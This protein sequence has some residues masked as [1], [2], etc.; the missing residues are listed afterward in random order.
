MTIHT[1]GAILKGAQREE[2]AQKAKDWYLQGC[3]IQSTAEKI[4]RS[5]GATRQLLLEA[6]VK[7]RPRGGTRTRFGSADR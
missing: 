6:G 5:Y 4:G 3:T 2:T 1:P 7:L